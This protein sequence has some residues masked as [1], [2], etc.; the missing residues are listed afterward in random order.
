MIVLTLGLGLTSAVSTTSTNLQG[1]SMQAITHEV[2]TQ[3]L[4]PSGLSGLT[5][6]HTLGPI[7]STQ[8]AVLMAWGGGGGISLKIDRRPL[9]APSLGAGEVQLH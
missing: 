2:D 6:W 5:H 7:V 4:D 8:F 3:L 9:V 1:Y